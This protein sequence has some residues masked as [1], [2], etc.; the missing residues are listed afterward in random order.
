MKKLCCWMTVLGVFAM[1]AGL[2]LACDKHK[3][4]TAAGKPGCN[5][6]QLVKV[7]AE[8]LTTVVSEK[9]PG[10]A[11]SARIAKLVGEKTKA[12]CSK[13]LA[14]ESRSGCHLADLPSITYRVGEKNTDCADQ[15]KQLAGDD[16]TIIY[17]VGD[18][19]FKSRGEAVK[20]VTAALKEKSDE[21]LSVRM[22]V[23]K[24]CVRCPMAA[25]QLAKDSGKP[26]RYAAVAR[27]FDD[28]ADAEAAVVKAREI[29]K[30]VGMTYRVDGEATRCSMTAKKCSTQGKKV[31]YVIGDQ[32]TCCPEE[33]EML[34]ERAKLVA[35][36]QAAQQPQERQ[37]AKL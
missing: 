12:G 7:E 18:K 27:V 13:G 3:E 23:G 1:S 26:V 8:G 35:L 10:C 9:K 32:A 16:G 4:A 25:K 11:F 2:V 14:K 5:K 30:N 20:T 17:L 37:T 29:I 34:L 31:E 33:A 28:K 36:I 6:S 19:S 15:A 22:M 21:L 24:E